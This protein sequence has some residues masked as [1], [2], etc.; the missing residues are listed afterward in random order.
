MTL[1]S[2]ARGLAPHT[3]GTAED[4][5]RRGAGLLVLA[6][7]VQIYLGA[8]VAG[9]DAGFTYNTWPLMDG[10]IVP[11]DLF[12]V[13]PAWRN[14]FENPKTVQFDHR[15]F[16]YALWL[17]ALIHMVRTLG[18]EGAGAPHANRAIVLFGL[19]TLQAGF[20]ITALVLQVPIEWGLIHQATA[21][22]AL[23]FAVAHWRGT[24]DAY[25]LPVRTEAGGNTGNP[26]WPTPSTAT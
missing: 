14:V 18:R 9:L 23:I 17:F 20:G 3:G 26:R 22:V 13:E 19:V 2:V 25:P 7:F 5:T 8:L 6:V 16:G 24:R 10:R 15:M 11:A 12:I 1:K 4:G 21:L